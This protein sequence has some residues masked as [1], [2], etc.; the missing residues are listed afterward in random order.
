M[1]FLVQGSEDNQVD[2]LNINCSGYS[3]M[4]IFTKLYNKTY[5]LGNKVPPS[6]CA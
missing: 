5:S 2:L 4:V 1:H 3:E 6:S